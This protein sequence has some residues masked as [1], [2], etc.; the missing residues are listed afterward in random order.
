LLG[1]WIVSSVFWKIYVYYLSQATG[2]QLAANNTG[3]EYLFIAGIV[4][5]IS[6]IF[7]R[8]IEIQEENQLTV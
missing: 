5:V 6:Q 4:Y 7:K 8:G 2:I 3:D 1:V